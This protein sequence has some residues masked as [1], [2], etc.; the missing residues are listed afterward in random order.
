MTSF[1]LS[2]HN[3]T[4]I[5]IEIIFSIITL[6]YELASQC[7]YSILPIRTKAM[8]KYLLPH[9]NA[10]S[11]CIQESYNYHDMLAI[12]RRTSVPNIC[13]LTPRILCRYYS[14]V[15]KTMKDIFTNLPDLLFYTFC[16]GYFDVLFSLMFYIV[17]NSKVKC[18]Y[19]SRERL[20]IN[21]SMDTIVSPGNRTTSH[22]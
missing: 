11:L 1:S 8:Y 6:A 21:L 13:V 4:T 3:L 19:Y 7:S 22:T 16:I 9:S 17:G 5:T 15:N 14:T 20:E 12:N 2:P 10:Y 18:K